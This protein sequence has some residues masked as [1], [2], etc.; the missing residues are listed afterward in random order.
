MLIDLSKQR[1]TRGYGLLEYFLSNQRM[2]VAINIIKKNKKNGIILDIGCGS[3]PF[4]LIKCDFYKRVGIDK[5]IN[6]RDIKKKNLTLYNHDFLINNKLPFQKNHFDVI[7]MLAVIEHIECKNVIKILKECNSI[8]KKDGLIIITTPTKWSFFL[9]K[10]LA[11][12]YLV[13]KKEIEDHKCSFSL[14]SITKNLCKANFK[15]ETIRGGYFD[16]FLNS[17]IYTKK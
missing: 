14:K 1:V 17:W 3:Y 11:K 9:L 16:F 15:K 5:E 2:K 6:N 4:F 13:S 8:L 7:T 12:L 10:I